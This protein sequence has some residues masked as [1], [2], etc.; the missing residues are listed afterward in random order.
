M[1]TLEIELS[2]EFLILIIFLIV[3][4]SINL[5]ITLVSPIAFGD[6]GFHT[7]LARW[8]SV[9]KEIP[10]FLPLYGTLIHREGFARP[11]LWNIL[12]GFFYLFGF[13]ETIVKILVPFITLLSGLSIYSL[14]KR[15]LNERTSLIA[16]LIYVSLPC[17]VTYSVLF[18]VDML[19]NFWIIL[20][21]GSF[22]LWEKFKD[23]KYLL[24]ST[25]F[26]GLAILTKTTGYF[27]LLFYFFY[28]TFRVLSEK[29]FEI[30]KDFGLV[31][32]LLFLTLSGWMIRNYFFF[33]TPLTNL[34]FNV[35][36]GKTIIK[37]DYTPIHEF[38][39]RIA[40]IATE[41]TVF[42]IGLVEYFDFAYGF[43]W[44]FPLLLFPSLL[45]LLLRKE[46]F[47][48]LILLMLIAALPGIYIF[49]SA[50]AED[51]AR[52]NLYSV[53]ILVLIVSIYLEKI[54]DWSKRYSK[55][56][57]LF[58]IFCIAI[59]SFLNFLG[60]ANMMIRVKQFFPLFL[61]ACNWIKQNL[62]LNASLLSLHTHPTVYNCE[63][64][65]I[66]ELVDLPDILLSNDINLTLNRLKANGIDYIFVQ[67]FSLSGGKYRQTYPITFVQ[68]LENNS[69]Y[70]EKVYENGPN[71]AQCLA[72]GGCDGT[73]LYKVNY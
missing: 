10:E 7:H 73:I 4:F 34:P 29:K 43:L 55:Y 35:L 54:L 36:Q 1:A 60:K 45:Y 65:A 67:K 52:Y 27:L 30:L 50:R 16:A 49:I 42:K 68:F 12:E 59:I 24:L 17:I 63:R 47:D 53:P 69:E 71:L 33:S 48:K 44:F 21:L 2:S 8:I 40:E 38:E 51:V 64:K 25:L 11:P 15:V 14:F 22:C 66:W 3:T 39:G 26:T 37:P 56:L 31:I 28:F 72:M 41:A 32:S 62:P 9:H 61:E 5:Y 70:F 6:E 58:L 57:P 23:K 20:S 18:Y 46:K 19:V 13:N